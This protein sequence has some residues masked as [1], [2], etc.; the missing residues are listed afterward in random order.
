MF[1]R[2]R[3]IENMDDVN[4]ILREYHTFI[5][6]DVD[7]WL[8]ALN[9]QGYVCHMEELIMVCRYSNWIK[10]V[11][12]GKKYEISENKDA[13]QCLHCGMI[14]YNPNDIKEKYCGNCHVFL[15]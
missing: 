1:N 9:K 6:F 14:S 13:I 7:I 11:K 2:K 12:E 4:N 5:N 10:I 8:K 15:K 3:K